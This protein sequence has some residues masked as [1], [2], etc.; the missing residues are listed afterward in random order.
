MTKLIFFTNHFP[1]GRGDSWK[2]NELMEFLNKFE[3]ITIVPFS[4]GGNP[5]PVTLPDGVH[6]ISP[7]ATDRVRIKWYNYGFLVSSRFFC[8]AL[9][10]FSQKVF[11]RKTWFHQWLVACFWIEIM[12]RNKFISS[13]R[14]Q[15]H[16]TTLYFYWGVGCG[17]LVPFLKKEHFKKIVVRFHGFDL[18]EERNNGYIPFRR[19]LLTH[20]S[21]AAF[22]SEHGKNY[23]QNR[24]PDLNF[25]SMVSRLGTFS[26]GKSVQSS[27]GFYRIFSCSNLISLKRVH[28]IAQALQFVNFPVI[29]THIGDGIQKNELELL[30]KNLPF[31]IQVRLVGQIDSNKVH[32]FYVDQPADL[33]INVS[34]TEGVPVSIMEAFA[35]SIPVIATAVGGIPEI[36]D[37]SVGRLLPGNCNEKDIA[38]A[39]EQFF[40]LPYE[41]LEA[42]RINAFN[43]FSITCNAQYWNKK[44]ADYL[45]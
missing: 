13:L 16:N 1:Y 29:W 25:E 37:C 27:D 3:Q 39:L 9:E 45:F 14:K 20:L 24:Y 44:M 11:L 15:H 30:I 34:E 18:Y 38:K 6:L 31:H 32:H 12:F 23:I 22:I 19:K 28:L 41:Q 2:R 5:V 21:T 36:V 10:F 7:L 8:Y 26:Y 42:L 35:A 43:R 40:C 17:Y 4:N 33:F